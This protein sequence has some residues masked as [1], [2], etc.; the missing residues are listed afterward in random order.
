MSATLTCNIDLLREVVRAV[1]REGLQQM[2]KVLQR[3]L[4]LRTLYVKKCGKQFFNRSLRHC[5][6]YNQNLSLSY[7][8]RKLYDRTSDAPFGQ[9]GRPLLLRC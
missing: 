4:R 5:T 2:L 1:V 7:H 6:V 9:H 3:C 8:T